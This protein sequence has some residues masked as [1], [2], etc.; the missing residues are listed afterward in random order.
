MSVGDYVRA[1]SGSRSEFG[2]VVSVDGNWIGVR[3]D[4]GPTIDFAACAVTAPW[5]VTGDRRD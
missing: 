5:E 4:S 3:L 2:T 1:W